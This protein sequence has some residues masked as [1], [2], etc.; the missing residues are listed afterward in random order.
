MLTHIINENLLNNA[1]RNI[2]EYH[3]IGLRFYYLFIK[4]H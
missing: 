1:I 4:N 2:K 3:P